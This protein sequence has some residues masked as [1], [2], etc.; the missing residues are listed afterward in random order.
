MKICAY[1]ENR[2][3]LFEDLKR[4][5]GELGAVVSNEPV[6]DA[7]AYICIRSSEAQK[8]P[9]L[10]RTLVQ[11]HDM[12][13]QRLNGVGCISL[14]HP[15]QRPNLIEFS[16]RVVVRPIGSREVEVGD[17]PEIPTIGFF[18]REIRQLK[19]SHLFAEAVNLARK[20]ANFSVLLV[21]KGLDSIAHLGRYEARP[22]KPK[23]YQR[24][25]GLAVCSVSPMIP[26]S[27][28]EA[29]AAGR[30][31]ITTPREWPEGSEWA[32]VRTGDDAEELAALFVKTVQQPTLFP[33][34]MPFSRKEW[35]LHQIEEAIKLCD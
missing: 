15:I 16:G 21:G 34:E 9:K 4:L 1:C 7:D 32:M 14:V 3:W 8:S 22:A 10:D 23:D 28:Y 27:A 17:L 25:T 35:A 13:A 29:C 5:F 26:L 20:S 19:R 11:I 18:C 31:V 12:K 6:K 2:G 33:P 24:I 30:S